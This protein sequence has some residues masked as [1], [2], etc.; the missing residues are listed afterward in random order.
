MS[1]TKKFMEHI[2]ALIFHFQDFQFKTRENHLA[3]HPCDTFLSDCVFWGILVGKISFNR[4]VKAQCHRIMRNPPFFW[5]QC[6]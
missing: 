3:E 6:I 4:S 2:S 5:V 1:E